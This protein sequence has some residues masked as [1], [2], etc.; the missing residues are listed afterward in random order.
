MSLICMHLIV[1]DTSVNTLN[2]REKEKIMG[3]ILW[4]IIQREN[5]VYSGNHDRIFAEKKKK[6]VIGFFVVV[7]VIGGKLFYI[8]FF[9]FY[10]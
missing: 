6:T 4:V 9:N 10:G 5:V 2:N 7:V 3:E 8:L 1:G